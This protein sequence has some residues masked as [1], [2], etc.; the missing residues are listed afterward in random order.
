VVAQNPGWIADI[1]STPPEDY[2]SSAWATPEALNVD[3]EPLDRGWAWMTAGYYDHSTRPSIGEGPLRIT[4]SQLLQVTGH[5][6]YFAYPSPDRLFDEEE[7]DAIFGTIYWRH[8]QAASAKPVPDASRLD[9]LSSIDEILDT[10]ATLGLQHDVNRIRDFIALGDEDP[11]QQPLSIESLK[12]AIKFKLTSSALPD[13]EIGIGGNG[14]ADLDWRL[15]PEG[16]IALVFN[17]S[18]T[19]DFALTIPHSAGAERS[20][21]SGTLENVDAIRCIAKSY[22]A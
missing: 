16:M 20:V 15:S 12:H 1:H 9:E 17:P 3:W 8:G 5:R 18:G 21:A 13:S 19:V 7:I 4:G 2:I 10:A 6:R 14:F 22:L 11:D